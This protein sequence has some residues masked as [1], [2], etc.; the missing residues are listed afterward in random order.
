[1]RNFIAIAAFALFFSP[2]LNADKFAFKADRMTGGRAAGKETTVLIGNAEVS[3]DKLFIRADR[4]ELSGKDNQFVECAGN[5]SGRE[6]DKQILFKTDKLSYDRNSKQLIMEGNSSLEDKKNEVVARGR[7][8]E[9]DDSTE[10]AVFQI[11]VRLFKDEIVCRSEHAIYRREE[12]MLDLSG[13][14]VVYKKDDEF[15][16]DRISVNLDN[17]DVIMEGAVSGSIKENK[18]DEESKKTDTSGASTETTTPATV[19]PPTEAVPAE[20]IPAAE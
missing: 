1:M 9:Y 20:A 16:A 6:D 11:S 8:I 19:T 18:E 3:S 17:D 7:R 5:I 13:F 10:I 12:K 2:A 15:R 4:I 14:P